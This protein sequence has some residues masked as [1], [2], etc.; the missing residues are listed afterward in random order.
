MKC[1]SLEGGH[2]GKCGVA[3][4][5]HWSGVYIHCFASYDNDWVLVANLDEVGQQYEK[6]E[7]EQQEEVEDEKE[8]GKEGSIQPGGRETK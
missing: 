7:E 6:Q 5:W 1:W 4:L 2:G 8:D 3:S